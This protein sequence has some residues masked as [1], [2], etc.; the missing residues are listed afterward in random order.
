M[1]STIL[2]PVHISLDVAQSA[3]VVHAVPQ[4][5]GA[6]QTLFIQVVQPFI[7]P[8]QSGGVLHGVP[9]AGGGTVVPGVPGTVVPGVPGT[10][11]PGVPGVV[12]VVGGTA[13]TLFTQAV[14][15]PCALLHSAGVVHG[16]PQTGGAVVLVDSQL[17]DGHSERVPLIFDA[18]H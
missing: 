16:V 17:F 14:Q 1:L 12:E 4:A 5:G 7:A 15:P 11:V 9:Q 10:V 13:Q 3:G 2:H 18:L 6:V 8:L